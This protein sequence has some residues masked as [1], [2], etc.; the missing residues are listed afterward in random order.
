LDLAR[1]LVY[2]STKFKEI[3]LMNLRALRTLA[4][5][6][7]NGSFIATAARLHMTASAV[8]MQMKMLERELGVALFDRSFRPPLI[9]PLG[10]LVAAKAQIMLRAN[11]DLLDACRS[12]DVLSGEFRMGFVPTS[13]VRLLPDFLARAREQHPAAHF[14]IETGLSDALVK[15]VSIGALDAAVV[16]GTDDIPANIHMQT[17]KE[18]ELV[19]CM[20]PSCADWAIDEC[21]AKLTFIHFMPMSG[22]GRLIAQ[23]MS[24]AAWHPSNSFVLDSVEAVAEC[25]MK[26]IGFSIL[27]EPDIR[28]HSRKDQILLR[29]LAPEPLKR[30]LVLASVSGG[31]MQMYKD[32]LIKLF[33]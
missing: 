27:P 32:S 19:F 6:Q 33:G 22:I 26:G 14:Q 11:D 29:A 20:P 5:L 10:R 13:S 28:R 15:M 8:S 18:E 16:T 12:T 25:V 21:M 7:E 30:L 2:L 3:E 4:A 17:V 31:R 1:N 9:T 24:R 23:Y